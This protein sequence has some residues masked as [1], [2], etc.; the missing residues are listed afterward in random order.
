MI[1]K[2]RKHTI[3]NICD[4]NIQIYISSRKSNMSTDASTAS[5]S[6]NTGT[7]SSVGTATASGATNLSTYSS[8]E[9]ERELINANLPSDIHIF[10]E[11][12]SATWIDGMKC[13]AVYKAIAG[14]AG[15]EEA[16]KLYDQVSTLLCLN[17]KIATTIND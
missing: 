1:V 2:Y 13:A 3:L 5:S 10:G 15:K 17:L 7:A 6:N 12:W 9:R 11:K 16:Q 14:E 8:T 4:S